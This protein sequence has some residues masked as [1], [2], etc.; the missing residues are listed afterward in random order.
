[1]IPRTDG[2]GNYD[3]VTNNPIPYNNNPAYVV[4]SAGGYTDFFVHNY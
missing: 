1:M 4:L 3:G 2:P